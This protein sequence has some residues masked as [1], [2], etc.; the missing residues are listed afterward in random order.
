LNSLGVGAKYTKKKMDQVL[1]W[2]PDWKTLI[3]KE[4]EL[5]GKEQTVG[6]II[7]FKAVLF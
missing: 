3:K 6:K 7:I 2:N 5:V 1:N 4:T